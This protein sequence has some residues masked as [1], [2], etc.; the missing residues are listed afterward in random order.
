MALRKCRECGGQVSSEAPTCPHC[1]VKKPVSRQS[2]LA[3]MVVVLI[4]L[5]AIGNLA[6][7]SGSQSPTPSPTTRPQAPKTTTNRPGPT[8][9]VPACD[10][11]RQYDAWAKP[12]SAVAYI[13][14]RGQTARIGS[15]DRDDVARLGSRVDGEWVEVTAPVSVDPAPYVMRIADLCRTSPPELSM[16]RYQPSK[17]AIFPR[18]MTPAEL[19]AVNPADAAGRAEVTI[20]YPDM[21]GNPTRRVRFIAQKWYTTRGMARQD[22]TGWYDW[23]GGAIII[24]D[25]GGLVIRGEPMLV[26]QGRYP[27]ARHLLLA[28]EPPPSEAGAPPLISYAGS[29]SEGID[30]LILEPSGDPSQPSHAYG[31]KAKCGR[32]GV[33]SARRSQGPATIL[34]RLNTLAD[35]LCRTP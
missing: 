19:R 21:L 28:E 11:I 14:Y 16:E 2:K 30:V 23:I 26:R 4:I 20:V 5:A 17:R 1:G 24:D 33:E 22:F 6:R 3:T 35:S 7:E 18:Q 32:N 34:R 25:I 13:Y 12:K 31:I 27:A 8:T 9:R 15:L 10:P 29:T